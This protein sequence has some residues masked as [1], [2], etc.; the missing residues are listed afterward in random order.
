[1]EHSNPADQVDRSQWNLGA[2]NNDWQAEKRSGANATLP[3][4][5]GSLHGMSELT[6]NVREWRQSDEI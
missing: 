4:D 5:P 6:Q 1:M 3:E 2:F